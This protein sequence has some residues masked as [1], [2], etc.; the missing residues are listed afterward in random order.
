MGEPNITGRM[1]G[2]EI[3]PEITPEDIARDIFI[4][5]IRWQG[6]PDQVHN[7]GENEYFTPKEKE[8]VVF[9]N[10]IKVVKRGHVAHVYQFDGSQ[11]IEIRSRY[12]LTLIL[13]DLRHELRINNGKPEPRAKKER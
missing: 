12:I 7:D 5:L 13:N 4:T 9:R 3:A 11:Q 6:V 2:F 10:G 8:E 1:K